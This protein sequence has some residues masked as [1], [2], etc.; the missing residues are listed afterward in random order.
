MDGLFIFS[1]IVSVA[2]IALLAWACSK[3]SR[4]LDQIFAQDDKYLAG[5][6]RAD[7]EVAERKRIN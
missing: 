2:L 7:R 3:V 5:L 4:A 1:L 6:S